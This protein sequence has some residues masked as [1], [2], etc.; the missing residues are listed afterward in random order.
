MSKLIIQT[1]P[2]VVAGKLVDQFVVM[3]ES[4]NLIGKKAHKSRSD[5]EQELGGLK[6]YAKGLE[7]ARATAPEGAQ[8]KSLVGK[9]N[10][11]AAFLLWQEMGSQTAEETTEEVTAT[12]EAVETAETVES[13]DEEF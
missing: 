2:Q 10:V 4:G 13:S 6:F 9:A 11:V 5:A 3:D 7:F 12:E 1:L 8:E